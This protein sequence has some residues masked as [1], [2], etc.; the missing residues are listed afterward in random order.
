METI[1]QVFERTAR[2][3]AARPAMRAKRGGAWQTITWSQYRDQVRLAARGLMALG[4]EPGKG[5]AIMGFNR[6]E[7]FVADVATIMAGGLPTGLYATNTLEQIGYIAEHSGA[8]VAVVENREYLSRFLEIRP[9][10]SHLRTIVVME[11]EDAPGAP[12]SGSQFSP[13]P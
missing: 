2:T 4:L 8:R 6:P 1:P 12:A 3:H 11:P 13:T 9:R 7:W 10:L 5:V